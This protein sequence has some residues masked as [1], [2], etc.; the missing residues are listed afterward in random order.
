[1]GNKQLSIIYLDC[2]L[3]MVY[4]YIYVWYDME[5]NGMECDVMYGMNIYIHIHIYYCISLLYTFM[6][7]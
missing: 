7:F 1:M 4:I 2:T 6:G 5:W 3:Y